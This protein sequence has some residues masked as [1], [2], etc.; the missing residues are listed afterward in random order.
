MGVRGAKPSTSAAATSG[1]ALVRTGERDALPYEAP[2]ELSA[3]AARMWLGLL[4]D[5][6]ASG[7]FRESDGFLLVELCEMWSEA[8][9]FRRALRAEPD[10]GGAEAKRLRAGYLQSMK[11]VMS[12][13]SEFGISPVARL[14][15]GLMQ[16]QGA[17]LLGVL[18]GE[19]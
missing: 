2:E 5:L 11:L 15:L 1:G 4:P 3:G 6:I 16:V 13:A 18:D 7:T 12:I 10:K 17:T 9:E 8:Q 19:A 14:R